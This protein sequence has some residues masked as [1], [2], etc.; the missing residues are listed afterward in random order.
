MPD[1]FLASLSLDRLRMGSVDVWPMARLL[2][3]EYREIL[4][5]RQL[6]RLEGLSL[7]LG[8]VN[9]TC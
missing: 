5:Q 8:P 3:L 2:P 7:L 1:G 6:R 9:S 4:T